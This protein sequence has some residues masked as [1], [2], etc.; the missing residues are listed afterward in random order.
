MAANEI[1]IQP[2]QDSK[3][4]RAGM[5]P[6]H[7]RLT[8]SATDRGGGSAV[9]RGRDSRAFEGQVRS[10]HRPQCGHCKPFAQRPHFHAS[11]TKC[12]QQTNRFNKRDIVH[13]SEIVNGVRTKGTYTVVKARRHSSGAYYEYQLVDSSNQPYKNGAWVREKDL[14]MEKRGG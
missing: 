14:R 12:R 7:T 11:F 3:V 1:E 13:R 8:N 4:S 10:V 6:C 9:G 2:A 5:R